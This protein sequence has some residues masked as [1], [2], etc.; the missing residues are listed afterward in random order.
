M[1][2]LLISGLMFG[3]LACGLALVG[4]QEKRAVVQQGGECSVNITGNNNT[5]ASLVCN[6]STSH[7]GQC[8]R[9]ARAKRRKWSPKSVQQPTSSSAIKTR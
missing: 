5:T 3:I 4:A 7:P 6:G 9:L 1:K 2:L 8:V